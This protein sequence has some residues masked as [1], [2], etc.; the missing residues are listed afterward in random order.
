M[1]VGER[2]SLPPGIICMPI[3]PD[4]L[5]IFSYLELVPQQI[6]PLCMT[7]KNEQL[8]FDLALT[9]ELQI[10]V[11]VLCASSKLIRPQK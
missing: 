1:H 4:A 11:N 7:L 3:S 9:L 6:L 10:F 8:A 5:I 2:E